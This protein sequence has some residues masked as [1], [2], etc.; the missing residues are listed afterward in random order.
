MNSNSI[1]LSAMKS[2]IA[3]STLLT[4]SILTAGLIAVSTARAEAADTSTEKSAFT[5][6]SLFNP[7][8]KAKPA[9][10]EYKAPNKRQANLKVNHD[11]LAKTD[12]S[13]T[14]VVVDI[15][16][17]RAYLLSGNQILID[18]PIST[19]RSGKYTPRGSFRITQRV[20]KGKRSSIYGCKMP[21]WMRLNQTA[22]GL[23]V[24][25]LPGHP[26]SAGCVRLPWRAASLIFSN[27]KSGTKVRI[28]SSWDQASRLV[29]ENR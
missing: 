6:S 14:E 16:H 24:G 9:F 27:T 18:T 1:Q 13:K 20:Q 2:T 22:Y 28:V 26:A 3:K 10:K 5:L 11:L 21:N 15:A 12:R 29:A 25:A 8:K 19:A 4:I 7:K 23:H 17:Q